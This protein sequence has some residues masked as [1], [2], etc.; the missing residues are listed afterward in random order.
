MGAID[1][2]VW[3]EYV[4]S[5]ANLADLPSRDEF[6]LL[7]E[8]GSVWVSTVLPPIGGDWS[9]VF[10]SYFETLAGKPDGAAKRSIARTAGLAADLR[11]A[12]RARR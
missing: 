1:A 9:A 11:A 4:P 6:T 10:F 7:R 2:N 12:K 3:L 5:G 8:W